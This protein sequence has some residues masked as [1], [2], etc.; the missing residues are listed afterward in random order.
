M[1]NSRN[2]KLFPKCHLPVSIHGLVATFSCSDT[3]NCIIGKCG[4][5][6]SAKLSNDYFNTRSTS[7]NDST[8]PSDICDVD[9][10][11]DNVDANFIS[12]YEWSRSEDNKLQ[13][14]LFKTSIDQSIVLLNSAV[15][16]LKH[17]YVHV[18][19]V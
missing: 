10:E 4:E 16:I 18:K 12:Y 9:G 13:K 14:V 3:G 11:D 15:K 2:K 5:Y 17:L 8:S 19:R 7:D 6:S 1:A